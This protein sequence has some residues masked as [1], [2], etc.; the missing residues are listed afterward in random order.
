VDHLRDTTNEVSFRVPYW[1]DDAMSDLTAAELRAVGEIVRHTTHQVIADMRRTIGN[2][3][4]HR[5]NRAAR[6][7]RGAPPILPPTPEPLIRH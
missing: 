6:I 5:A 4:A 1:D 2:V 3:A 7:S